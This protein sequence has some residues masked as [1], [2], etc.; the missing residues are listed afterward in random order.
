MSEETTILVID[1]EIEICNYLKTLINQFGYRAEIETSG[2]GGLQALQR[3]RPELVILD[4]VMPGMDGLEVLKKIKE[5]GTDTSVVMLSG[6]RQTSTVVG[7]MKLGAVDFLNKPFDPD[8]LEFTISKVLERRELIS[9]VQKL[10][11]QVGDQNGNQL[12]FGNSEKMGTIKEIIDQ[13]S[14]TDITVLIKGESGT[15]KG[16][17]ARFLYTNSSRRDQRFVKVNCAALPGELLESELFG[18]ERGAFT[19]AHKK[20]PGKFEFAHKGTIF[21]DEIGEL[22]SALQAK[23]LQVLQD[24]EFSPLG[25]GR[26][27]RVDSRVIAATNRDLETEVAQGRFREDLFFRLN[28]VNITVPP[29]RERMEEIPVLTEHFLQKYSRKYNKNCKKV[30]R[31]TMDLFMQYNWPG[32]VRE[33]EN[34]I[35]RVVVLGSEKAIITEFL[36]REEERA[37]PMDGD[38]AFQAVDKTTSPFEERR[39]IDSL[40]EG[41]E[42]YTLRDVSKKASNRAEKELIEKILRENNWN[43]KKTSRILKVSYK[44]LLY[45]IK[46]NKIDKFASY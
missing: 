38:D 10:K 35:K 37:S 24:G 12:L 16:L 19:G 9:E 7:A 34:M 31:D 45:K 32:N 11:K 14:D 36:L 41:M 20:K 43:R 27:I 25:S 23:L 22:P 28:V 1:D 15:G 17:I 13:V 42:N 21:L 39:Y 6:H 2:R 40:L 3:I 5:D 8:E 26:D 44:A 29:L 4:V 30:S 33:L 46:E 18:Y